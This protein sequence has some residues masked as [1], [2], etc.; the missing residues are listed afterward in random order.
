M[1]LP[2]SRVTKVTVARL[3]FSETTMNNQRKNGRPNPDQKYFQ[4]AVALDAKLMDGDEV[5]IINHASEKVN[6]HPEESG[7][8]AQFIII[9]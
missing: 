2:A 1:D 7:T 8:T 4:L 3:H 5:N 9:Y 6:N